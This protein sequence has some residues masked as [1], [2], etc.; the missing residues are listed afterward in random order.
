MPILRKLACLAGTLILAAAL[1]A[2]AAD[3]RI[4]AIVAAL[5]DQQFDKALHLLDAALKESP[6][7]AQLWTMQGVA[8]EGLGK[9]KEALASFR[10]ALKL[11]PDY[12]PAL[13]KSAQIA[14]D[15]GDPA[16]IPVLEHLLRLR[17][18]DLTSHAMLAVLEYQKGDCAAASAP[19]SK[20]PH[21]FSNPDCRP[22]MLTERA[23]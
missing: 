11:S 5:R 4:A 13:E 14:F 8:R 16:G 15:A 21:P 23:S 2:Q 17:P 3:A 6:G 9:N 22:C 19:L 18:D 20:R 7:N 12:I 10:H 1:H